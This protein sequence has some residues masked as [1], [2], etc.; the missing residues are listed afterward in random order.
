MA[1][2]LSANATLMG[3]LSSYTVIKELHKAADEGAMYLA[4]NQRDEKCIVKSIRGHWRLQNEA[5]IAKRY[6]S[7]TPFLRPLI[8]EIQEPADPPSIVLGY[9]DSDMLTESNKKRLSRPEIKQVARCILEALRVFHKDGM[10]HT[11]VKLDNIFVN[12]GQGDNRFSDME[13]G[14]CGGVVSQESKFAKEGHI[15]GAAFTRSPEATFQLPWNTATDIW[16]FGNAIL[17]LLFGGNYHLFN[18]QIDRVPPG[19]DAYEFTVLKRMHRFFGP[20]PQSYETFNDPDTITIINF[21]NH[22]EPPA[23]PFTRVTTRQIPLADKEFLLKIMKL[24]PRDRPTAGELLA[25]EW[26]TEESQDTRD[27]LP[28]EVKQD[29]GPGH[30]GT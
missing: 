11:D 26:F 15:I 16:S 1:R 23:K 18:P 25:D 28:G 12:H 4:R 29:V 6:Q 22:Q 21:I 19:H 8:D 10:V 9:L 5:E 3:R 30:A 7:Q 14:D 27:P 13:L 17:S 24:D 20:Y 2:L